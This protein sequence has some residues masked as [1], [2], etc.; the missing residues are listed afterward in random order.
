MEKMLQIPIIFQTAT[1]GNI[2]SIDLLTS[3]PKLLISIGIQLIL[4]ILLGYILAKAFKYIIAFILV[5]I[6]GIVLNVWSLSG[7]GDYFQ[8]ITG[9]KEYLQY[10]IELAK[11][12]S[13]LLVGPVM[14]GFVIGLI[15]GWLHK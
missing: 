7:S 14:A 1:L 4:G 11:L 13:A 9:S 10:F 5:L 2:S 8:K 15:I 12:M 6:A 3:N